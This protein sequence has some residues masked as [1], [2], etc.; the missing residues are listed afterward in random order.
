MKKMISSGYAAVCKIG[1]FLGQVLR[2]TLERIQEHAS[3][4]TFEGSFDWLI[5]RLPSEQI[6]Q[7][8]TD[9]SNTDKTIENKGENK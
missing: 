9:L 1:R 5:R 6:D 8:Q 4:D 3:A 7:K 2:C